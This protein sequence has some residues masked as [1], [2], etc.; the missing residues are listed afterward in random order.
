MHAHIRE[1]NHVPREYIVAVIL[2]SFFFIIF[3]LSDLVLV[4]ANEHLR[5]I[6]YMPFHSVCD[7]EGLSSVFLGY[8]CIAYVHNR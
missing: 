2:S 7:A 3:F 1:T 5:L 4:W 6:L 8:V